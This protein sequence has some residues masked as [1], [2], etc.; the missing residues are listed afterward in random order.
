[1]FQQQFH[2][3]GAL[4]NLQCGPAAIIR[5]ENNTIIHIETV[6]EVTS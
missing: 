5:S 6:L 4:P 2:N 1:M 3:F